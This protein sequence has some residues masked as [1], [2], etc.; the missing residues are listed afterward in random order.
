MS[1]STLA[2]T[3][4]SDGGGSDGG[5]GSDAGGDDIHGG[6]PLLR[7]PKARSYSTVP[8]AGRRRL[9]PD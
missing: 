2:S 5:G 9:T 7:P 8:K 6:G 3:E 4:V 1:Y